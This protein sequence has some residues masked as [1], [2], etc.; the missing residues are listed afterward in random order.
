MPCPVFVTPG[1]VFV[2]PGPVFVM[3]GPVFVMPGPDRASFVIP[4]AARVSPLGHGHAVYTKT[5]VFV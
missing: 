2:T 4:S 3:L 5:P 1:P